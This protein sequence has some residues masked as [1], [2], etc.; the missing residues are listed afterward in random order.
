MLAWLLPCP[1][2]CWARKAGGTYAGTLPLPLLLLPADCCGVVELGCTVEGEWAA[3]PVG[4]LTTKGF[5]HA[6]T[7]G[8][9]GGGEVEGDPDPD[10]A[11]CSGPTGLA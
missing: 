7:A 4:L 6:E 10:A 11:R 8:T 9:D 5:A 3:E 1:A 2:C